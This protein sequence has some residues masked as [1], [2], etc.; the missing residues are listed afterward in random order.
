MENGGS[1][2]TIPMQYLNNENIYAFC[3]DYHRNAINMP[4]KKAHLHALQRMQPSKINFKMPHKQ[5]ETERQTQINA[6]IEMQH[7][8][9]V[10]RGLKILGL[11]YHENPEE[12]FDQFISNPEILEIALELKKCKLVYHQRRLRYKVSFALN[13]KLP[14]DSEYALR[15]KSAL[16]IDNLMDALVYCSLEE[17]YESK[18]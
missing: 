6:A 11:E 13:K 9:L 15:L 17:L 14:E 7:A 5:L 3:K 10:Q 8:Q 12:L 4:E 1:D 2:D 16:R 18:E